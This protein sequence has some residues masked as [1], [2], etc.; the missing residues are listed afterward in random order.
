[1][2]ISAVITVLGQVFLEPLLRLFGASNE[3][4]PYAKA[5]MQIILGGTMI[6]T[7]GFG[8]NNFI[9]GEG[10]PRVA[11]NTMLIG[12]ILNVI[13][14]PILIFGLDLGIRGSALATVLAQTVSGAFVLHYFFSGRSTLKIRRKNL[15]LRG[16][17]VRKIL[18]LG[19]AQ[20]AMQLATVVV[21]TILNSRLLK[22][23]GD[24][25]ISGMGVVS[26]MQ[27]L[28]FMP[29][30][31]INQGVQPIIGFNYG[32]RKF[33]RVREAL[34]LAIKVASGIAILGFILIELFPWQLV[35]LFNSSDTQFMEFSV[36]ALR[37]F[38]ILLPLLG[39][40]TVGAGYFMSVGKPRQS[41]LLSLSRQVLFFIPAIV[42]LP[43]FWGL[44]GVILAGPFADLA[45]F[46]V[47]GF[48]LV[49]ELRHLEDKH[50]GN[51]AV[52]S[53]PDLV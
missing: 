52:E 45:S 20:F 33:D 13:L 3:V 2:M 12:T 25:A 19:S 18:A 6:Q 37:V 15:K 1:L 40:Q 49:R 34:Q 41:A 26:S 43:M 4:L 11:M 46:L 16:P 22:Y 30:I 36:Y 24:M 7:I 29:L 9:R 32:A 51:E 47:T 21:I 8:L 5:F 42:I 31:G 48:F 10:N 14:C 28:V 27:T 23:G 44:H 38:L 53:V 39:F 50:Q 35:G 17:L